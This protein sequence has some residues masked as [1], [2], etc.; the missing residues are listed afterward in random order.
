MIFLKRLFCKHQ[1]VKVR[2][3]SGDEINARDGRRS[4]WECVYCGSIILSDYPYK[5]K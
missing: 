4:E 3:I 5:L 1:Y 2:T